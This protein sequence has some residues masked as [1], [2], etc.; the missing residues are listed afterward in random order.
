MDDEINNKME[1]EKHYIA[2]LVELDLYETLKRL[3][4]NMKDTDIIQV[5][6]H[7]N[8]KNLQINATKNSYNLD[9]GTLDAV[10][11]GG[12]LRT[13]SLSEKG[14]CPNYIKNNVFNE[15]ICKQEVVPE[16]L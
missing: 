7:R 10:E 1:E 8:E 3:D 13:L 6:G 16:D 11:K 5:H 14:F 15:K 12:H 9:G 4:E 2:L